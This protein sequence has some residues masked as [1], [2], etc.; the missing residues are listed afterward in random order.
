[1]QRQ[2]SIYRG[3]K[4]AR[5]ALLRPFVAKASVPTDNQPLPQH[6]EADHGG[7]LGRERAINFSLVPGWLDF[8]FGHSLIFASCAAGS[9]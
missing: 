8:C 7:V 2:N 1:M 5:W 6:D 3:W 4:Q 9:V